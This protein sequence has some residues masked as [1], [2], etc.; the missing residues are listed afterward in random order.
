M[1]LRGIFLIF[2]LSILVFNING[3]SITDTIEN[4]P[5][6][7]V[8]VRLYEQCREGFTKSE[9]ENEAY[10]LENKSL[11]TGVEVLGITGMILIIIII[12]L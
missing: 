1:K 7:M 3:Q 10:R 4:K 6:Y 5:S 9:I 2:I 8:D 12:V 11:R